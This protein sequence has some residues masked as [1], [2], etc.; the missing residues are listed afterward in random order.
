MN[1]CRFCKETEFHPD[2]VGV[3]YS[4]RHF[5]HF[6]CYLN[7]GKPLE[8][9]TKWQVSRFPWQL[10]KARGLMEQATKLMAKTTTGRY[11]GT[12]P[13]NLKEVAR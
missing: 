10:L 6:V 8:A 5:A 2:R 4:T 1:T 12:G 9:L 7:A 3:M 11:T 13:G